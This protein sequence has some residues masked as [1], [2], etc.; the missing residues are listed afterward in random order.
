MPIQG[1][2]HQHPPDGVAPDDDR[3]RPLRS[4]AERRRDE[5]AQER[6]RCGRALR[7]VAVKLDDGD[8]R[9]AVV[10]QAVW[11]PQPMRASGRLDE[12]MG[13]VDVDANELGAR[14]RPGF[15]ANQRRTVRSRRREPDAV[16]QGVRPPQDRR[17]G[18]GGGA[19]LWRESS[20]PIGRGRRHSQSPGR[21]WRRGT[22]GCA[23]A[24]P[25]PSRRRRD[26]GRTSMRPA[27]ASGLRLLGS[28][29]SPNKPRPRMRARSGASAPTV[30][31]GERRNNV[32]DR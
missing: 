15:E 31:A 10:R 14:P 9:G 20:T 13:A 11:K 2:Q 3:S 16:D 28:W 6:E 30:R 12:K 29:Y 26:Q 24:A 5:V 8:Q 17:T 23:G 22:R 25:K 32:E 27:S 7:G 18:P 21:G 19:G 1:A 4:T